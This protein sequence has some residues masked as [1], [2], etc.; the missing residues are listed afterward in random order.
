MMSQPR[1]ADRC[2][3]TPRNRRKTDSYAYPLSQSRRASTNS[4]R[5]QLLQTGAAPPTHV[6]PCERPQAT[7]NTFES[8]V[9]TPL[10]QIHAIPTASDPARLFTT[11]TSLPVP[12]PRPGRV[13]MS[14]DRRAR[15]FVTV[16]LVGTLNSQ[17]FTGNI[18]FNQDVL[19]LNN[20][21]QRAFT[22]VGVTAKSA[23]KYYPMNHPRND[24]KTLFY[25]LLHP[26]FL[27]LSYHL[28]P[29]ALARQPHN[30]QT[31]LLDSAANA[32]RDQL[33]RL[34]L[35]MTATKF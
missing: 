7:Q 33:A 10:M 27:A 2:S 4:R 23:N 6:G 22:M 12:M 14:V 19:H 26:F 1:I 24:P 28:P 29:Q 34:L 16:V 20:I 17:D 11:A 35:T 31:V 18:I 32:P 3:S 25:L 15:S 21:V 5:S 9:V 13:N 30:S 8:M